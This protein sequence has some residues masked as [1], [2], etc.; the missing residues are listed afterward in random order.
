MSAKYEAGKKKALE[1]FESDSFQAPTLDK[2]NEVADIRVVT[3]YQTKDSTLFV[4]PYLAEQHH[5]EIEFEEFYDKCFLGKGSA[6]VP[7]EV[8]KN[9]LLEHREHILKFLTDSPVTIEGFKHD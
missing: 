9:W 6:E 7:H 3:A 8:I 4:E 1:E 2:I 5:R